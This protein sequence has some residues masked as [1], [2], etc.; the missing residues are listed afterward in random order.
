MGVAS[1]QVQDLALG[2]VEPCEI[3]LDNFILSFKPM[4]STT[5]F[6]VYV[7][8]KNVIEHWSQ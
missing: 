7:I 5:Q 2:F 3:V 1:T 6:D 4:D 8:N